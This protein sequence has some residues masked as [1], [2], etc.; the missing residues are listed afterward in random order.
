M[1][2]LPDP[3]SGTLKT[4][5]TNALLLAV[6]GMRPISLA[7]A[8]VALQLRLCGML[9]VAGASAVTFAAFPQRPAQ[10]IRWSP[11]SRRYRPSIIR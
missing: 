10:A 3:L 7:A 6:I 1:K 4:T 11:L 8:G 5:S 2:P 9:P